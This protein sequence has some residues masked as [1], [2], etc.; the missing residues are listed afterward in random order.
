MI[1][2]QGFPREDFLTAADF[3]C[4]YADQFVKNCSRRN[5]S[6]IG[7]YERF[8]REAT[9]KYFEALRPPRGGQEFRIA[10]PRT[11]DS[12]YQGFRTQRALGCVNPSRFEDPRCFQPRYSC[13][14]RDA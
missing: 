10:M 5:P 14:R 11:K 4:A 3:N 12:I 1:Y 2:R 13:H 6:S 9:P 7:R 8:K